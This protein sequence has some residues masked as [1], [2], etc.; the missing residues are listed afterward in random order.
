MARSKQPKTVP[1]HELV[2]QVI[3]GRHEQLL[4]RFRLDGWISAAF[5]AFMVTK[6]TL[7]PECKGVDRPIFQA[8]IVAMRQFGDDEDARQL[9]A[10]ATFVL[11]ADYKEASTEIRRFIKTNGVEGRELGNLEL[12]MR[13]LRSQRPK[14]AKAT[15]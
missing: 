14:K 4:E 13:A 10:R 3:G 2:V 6:G 11:C 15:A 5:C 7:P 9:C 1:F 12:F 8:I